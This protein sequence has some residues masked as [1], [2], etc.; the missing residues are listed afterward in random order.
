MSNV[1]NI[2]TIENISASSLT[3]YLL[4]YDS[5]KNKLTN[6]H[7]QKVIYLI[8][9]FTLAI[10]NISIIN[11]S[12]D[13]CI[14]AWKFGPVIPSIYHEFKHLTDNPIGNEKESIVTS[15]IDVDFP[16]F[17]KPIL[18][19]TEVKQIL[20]KQISDWVITNI[21]TN[22]NTLRPASKLVEL[23]HLEGSPWHQVFQEGKKHIEIENNRI[24]DYFIWY[25][26]WLQNKGIVY[27][28]I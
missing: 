14:E 11:H 12:F 24:Q 8:H 13:E 28:N 17:F 18:S 26:E 16:Q 1:Q 5:L 21:I 3:N 25:R 4:N 27:T 20:V 19:N 23:T 15:A 2:T 22:N 6:L 10:A 9:G 7:L